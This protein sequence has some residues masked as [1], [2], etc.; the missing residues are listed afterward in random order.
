M[1]R[2]FSGI[3]PANTRA[4]RSKKPSPA[5]RQTRLGVEV[6]EGRAMPS[7]TPLAIPAH[8]PPVAI[9]RVIFN[10]VPN[11]SGL[12]FHL[13]S[14]NGKPAHDLTITSEHYLLDGSATITGTWHGD[15]GNGNSFPI[16]N[17]MLTHDAHGNTI[18]TFSWNGAHYFRGTVTPVVSRLPVLSIFG[19]RYHLEGDV[20]VPGNPNGGPGHV[21]GDGRL[22]F[23]VLHL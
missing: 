4:T 10:P 12:T 15:G 9:N 18:M 17:G 21:S 11:L 7:V 3:R 6:L 8:L 13:I 2:L 19:P 16:V 5:R 14:S 1:L 20:T 22:A 23:P